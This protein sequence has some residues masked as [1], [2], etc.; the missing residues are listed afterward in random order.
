MQNIL[1]EFHK[2]ENFIEKMTQKKTIKAKPKRRKHS[3][4]TISETKKIAFTKFLK[5]ESAY[6]YVL[7]GLT[8]AYFLFYILHKQ[9][10]FYVQLNHNRDYS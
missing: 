9:I 3:S 2:V 8:L 1:F 6:E 7:N 4:E 10:I 5:N